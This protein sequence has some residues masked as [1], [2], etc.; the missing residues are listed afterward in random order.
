M[1]YSKMT[2][3]ELWKL[4]AKRYG[5]KWTMKDIT[6]KALQKEVASRLETGV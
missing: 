2:D 1:D 6:D 3:E 4:V 5:A